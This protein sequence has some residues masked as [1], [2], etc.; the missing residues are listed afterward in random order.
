MVNMFL[1]RNRLS[2]LTIGVTMKTVWEGALVYGRRLMSKGGGF[3][4]QH[5]ILD[6]DIFH[7]YLL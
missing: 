1:T 4:S 3:G 6:G 5:H 7:N 2:F